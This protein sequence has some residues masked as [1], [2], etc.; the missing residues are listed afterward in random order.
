[1]KEIENNLKSISTIVDFELEDNTYDLTILTRS[2]IR[3]F[4]TN[5][6]IN[7]NFNISN[8]F[9]YLNLITD[10][11]YNEEVNKLLKNVN[12]TFEKLNY[13]MKFDFYFTCTHY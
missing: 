8:S 11:G 10:R 9:K 6:L 3:D 12:K 1:M 7:I 2:D 5:I 13:I 4:L